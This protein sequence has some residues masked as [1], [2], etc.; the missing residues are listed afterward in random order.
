M[1]HSEI[2]VTLLGL[3]VSGLAAAIALSP[4]GGGLYETST[5]VYE[6]KT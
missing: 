6:L 1:V 2:F 3:L 4:D 5:K